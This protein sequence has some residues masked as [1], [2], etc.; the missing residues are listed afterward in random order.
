MIWN[1]WKEE[2]FEF[3]GVE[4]GVQDYL[5]FETTMELPSIWN[6][7]QCCAG[8]TTPKHSVFRLKLNRWQ[9]HFFWWYCSYS[10]IEISMLLQ[11]RVLFPS[12]KNLCFIFTYLSTPIGGSIYKWHTCIIWD[13]EIKLCIESLSW[14]HQLNTLL[15]DMSLFDITQWKNRCSRHR[16]N[17]SKIKK[18]KCKRKPHIVNPT[19]PW[20]TPGKR[21]GK[22]KWAGQAAPA[23]HN[24]RPEAARGGAS[25]KKKEEQTVKKGRKGETKKGGNRAPSRHGT[26]T[27]SPSLSSPRTNLL[28]LS[29]SPHC[30]PPERGGRARA[31][32][33]C[34]LVARTGRHQQRYEDGRRLVAGYARDWLIDYLPNYCSQCLKVPFSIGL[35]GDGYVRS[36]ARGHSPLDLVRCASY[37]LAPGTAWYHWLG[38]LMCLVVVVCVSGGWIA[39]VWIR[40]F[41]VF[42]KNST[43]QSGNHIWIAVST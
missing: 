3:Y 18:T 31:G 17:T 30:P 28:P 14:I 21:T 35:T 34:D 39:G 36:C 5:I 10:A 22:L 7:I 2:R 26:P 9:Q 43:V 19:C 16:A 25:G 29:P 23:E 6:R 24:P 8:V 11:H 38:G 13:R 1:L 37:S 42:P 15:D 27:S 20:I 41:L 32:S 12:R 40:F 33:M 4:S